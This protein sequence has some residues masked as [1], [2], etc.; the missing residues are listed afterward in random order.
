[1]VIKDILKCKSIVRPLESLSEILDVPIRGITED[2]REVKDGFIFIANRGSTYDGNKFLPEAVKNGA[3]LV[4]TDCPETYEAHRSTCP[5]VLSEDLNRS[6][7]EVTDLFY[8]FPSKRLKVVGITGTNGKTTTTYLLKHI[9][10]AAGYSTGV[11]GT[12]GIWIRDEFFPNQL[13]TPKILYLQS[14]LGLMADRGVEYCF[15]EVSSH[16]LVLGRIDAVVFECAIFTN[17]TRDHMD[18]HRTFENYYTAKSRLFKMCG[19]DKPKIINIDDEYGQRLHH[20][21]PLKSISYSAMD[22]SSD[23]LATDI[24][25]TMKETRFKLTMTS[26]METCEVSSSI[27]GKFNVYNILAA[28]AAAGSLISAPVSDIVRSVAQFNTVKG[29]FEKI[30]CPRRDALVIIDYAHTPD[31]L[32]NILET[33]REICTG[34]LFTIF[35]CGGDRDS[36]KRP[37]M[38]KIANDLSD[39]IIITSDNPRSEDPAAII[40][41]ILAGID[42]NSADHLVEADRKEA[43][44]IGVNM[45]NSGDI[46]VIAGKGHETYQILHD[47]VID[48]NDEAIARKFL[49]ES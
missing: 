28:I 33:A 41:D 1:M 18:F 10:H 32:V 2:S 31:G 44:R 8:S 13:T 25:I 20:D 23:Y 29:R 16:S 48:F 42:Q 30:Y 26:T 36:T 21:F 19:P 45:L 46:L 4:V 5:V 40:A 22:R 11:I 37:L 47:R 15:M 43:I 7:V 34:Q 6:C 9:F 39:R 27:L 3:V 35:G 17:L 24:R 14:I 49:F 38:G 12:N